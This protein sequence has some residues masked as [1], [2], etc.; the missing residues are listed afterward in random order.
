MG[1]GWQTSGF[2]DRLLSQKKPRLAG[3]DGYFAH[4]CPHFSVSPRDASIRLCSFPQR[5][6]N[7][8]FISINVGTNPESIRIP[9]NYLNAI[10]AAAGCGQLNYLQLPKIE[11]ARI[12][13]VKRT[14]LFT[15]WNIQ[16]LPI[17]LYP[18]PDIRL[19][20]F[21]LITLILRHQP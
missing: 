17:T 13:L 15:V 20:R 2:A 1:A 8:K 19:L 12:C 9:E 18:L 16:P 4:T 3:T 11:K 14:P 5:L 6:M 21:A 7:N 10:F